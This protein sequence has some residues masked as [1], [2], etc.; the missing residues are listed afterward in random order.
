[1]VFARHQGRGEGFPS[2]SAGDDGVGDHVVDHGLAPAS[3]EFFTDGGLSL[4][5]ALR[6]GSPKREPKPKPK[7]GFGET[8]KSFAKLAKAA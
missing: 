6:F 3:P 1:M 2:G 8:I 5:L 7:A 4:A